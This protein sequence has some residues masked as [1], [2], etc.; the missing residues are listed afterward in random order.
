MDDVLKSNLF[1][2]FEDVWL[3]KLVIADSVNKKKEQVI[4]LWVAQ[5][6]GGNQAQKSNVIKQ[7]KS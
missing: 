6:E 3:L 5:T 7:G 2:Y 4:I 1:L